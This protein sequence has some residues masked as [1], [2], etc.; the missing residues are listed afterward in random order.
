MTK[1]FLIPAKKN[2]RGIKNKNLIK[3]NGKSLVERTLKESF[4]SKLTDLI[5]VSSDSEDILD[6]ATEYNAIPIKRPKKFCSNNSNANSVILHFISVLPDNLIRANPWIF[7]LQPT[8]PLRKKKHLIEVCKLLKK[9]KSIISVYETEFNL[10]KGLYKKDKYLFP[11]VKEN[12]LTENRQNLK[13]TFYPNGGMYIFRIK[14]F[15]KKKKIPIFNSLPYIMNYKDSL[16][17]DSISD[18]K[19]LKELEK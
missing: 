6:I 19:I 18:L 3:I 13:K 4:S 8:S 5:Y 11:L 12:L 17:I 9:N 10:F 2:S 1:L 14:D 16:D 7:Y 15:L